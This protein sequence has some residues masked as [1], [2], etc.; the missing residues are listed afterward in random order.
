MGSNLSI[1]SSEVCFVL[2][3]WEGHKAPKSNIAALSVGEHWF[4]CLNIPSE[5]AHVVI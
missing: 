1:V 3:L 2:N 4:R 5:L